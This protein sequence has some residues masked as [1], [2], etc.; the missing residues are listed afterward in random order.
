MAEQIHIEFENLPSHLLE[1]IL[2]YIPLT[3]IVKLCAVC[4][5]L[6]TTGNTVIRKRFFEL[7]SEIYKELKILEEELNVLPKIE[8]FYENR[9][10]LLRC[11]YFLEML[12]SELSLIRAVWRR[13]LYNK[14][15]SV[16][17]IGKLLHEFYSAFYT[18][19]KF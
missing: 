1:S 8:V 11:Y 7:R 3:E 16:V 5:V 9:I 14:S 12:L 6:Y 13:V 10:V 19:S 17:A 15:S 18:V 2:S 4:Q